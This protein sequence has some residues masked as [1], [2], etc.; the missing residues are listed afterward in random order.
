M[1]PPISQPSIYVHQITTV[2]FHPRAD[3]HADA[4]RAYDPAHAQPTRSAQP[5]VD[6]LPQPTRPRAARSRAPAA[7]PADE[8]PPQP[9]AAEPASRSRARADEPPQTTRPRS[10]AQPSPHRA[11]D[12]AQTSPH[13][14]PAPAQ[15]AAESAQQPPQTTRPRSRAQPSPHRAAAPADSPALRDSSD[16]RAFPWRPESSSSSREQ[17]NPAPTAIPTPFSPSTTTSLTLTPWIAVIY[18]PSVPSKSSSP[19]HPDVVPIRLAPP[20]NQ[21]PRAIVSPLQRRGRS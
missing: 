12:P 9:R 16:I 21:N 20:R 10:R 4:Q 5:L 6:E 17:T 11:A 8:P 1:P 15:R 7:A 18:P 19:S 14:R 13:R 3:A 2:H